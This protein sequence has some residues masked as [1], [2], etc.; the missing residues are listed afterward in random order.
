MNHLASYGSTFFYKLVVYNKIPP[1]GKCLQPDSTMNVRSLASV[2]FSQ[3]RTIISWQAV[4]L[5][6]KRAWYRFIT[7]QDKLY[8]ASLTSIVCYFTTSHTYARK[9][10]TIN[11]HRT[12]Y[13]LMISHRYQRRQIQH[14]SDK[15]SIK[16]W[17]MSIWQSIL[18][19]RTR[20][21]TRALIHRCLV[22]WRHQWK[23]FPRYRPFVDSPHKGQWREL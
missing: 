16:V 9:T 23:H 14:S 5:P 22:W 3:F 21:S 20:S 13:P 4:C 2:L 8:I 12:I 11:N 10:P 18:G 19:I 17:S 7:C 1:C 6:D 15:L